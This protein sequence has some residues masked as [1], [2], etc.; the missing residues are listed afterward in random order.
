MRSIIG[1]KLAFYTNLQN[2]MCLLASLQ[3]P[4][5]QNN[6]D[7]AIPFARLKKN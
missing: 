1:S 4:T 7:E 6:T 5:K 3:K 2:K